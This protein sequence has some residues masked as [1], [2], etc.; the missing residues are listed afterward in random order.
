MKQD[1]LEQRV[2]QGL[3]D[4]WV[5][6]DLLEQLEPQALLEILDQLVLLDPLVAQD[7]QVQ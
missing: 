4:L 5:A 3:R 7:L 2:K 6:Q 1:Q